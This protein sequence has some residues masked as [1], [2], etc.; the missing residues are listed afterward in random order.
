MTQNWK[1]KLFAKFFLKI[2]SFHTKF[3]NFQVPEITIKKTVSGKK[4]LELGQ[5]KIL[6]SSKMTQN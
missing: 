2:A 5:K 4:Y 3:S 6:L 1:M